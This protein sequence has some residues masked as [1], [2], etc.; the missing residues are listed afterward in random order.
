MKTCRKCDETKDPMEFRRVK[1]RNTYIFRRECRSCERAYSAANKKVINERTRLWSQANSDRVNARTATYR[2][3]KRQATPKWANQ[4]YINLFYKIAKM[5]EAR[6]G[7][8]VDVD[9]IIPLR[10]K[11]VCGLHCEDNLQL[12]F[13][14]DNLI[15]GNKLLSAPFGTPTTQCL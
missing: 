9:H 1:N 4:G 15:K 13:K 12:L 6:T 7:R 3:N 2:A 10:G 5:E 8:R 11:T 14:E